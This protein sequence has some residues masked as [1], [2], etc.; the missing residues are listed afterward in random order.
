MLKVVVTAH[1]KFNKSIQQRGLMKTALRCFTRPVRGLMGALQVLSPTYRRIRREHAQWDVDHHVDTAPGNRP[2]WM[3]DI[4][5]ENW[6]HGRG[7]HPAPSESL[8]ERLQQL[9]TDFN[10]Y[11]FID[12]GS[13]KG[14]SLFTA[15][16]FPFKK[17]IGVEFNRSLHETA[18]KNVESY[19]SDQQQCF[20]IVPVL[21]DAARF[22]IPVGK[23]VFYFYDPFDETV[24]R[25][26]FEN[27][28][29]AISNSRE[30][31]F[32]VYYNPVF[33]EYFEEN[34]AFT[35]VAQGSEFENYWSRTRSGD[36]DANEF[37]SELKDSERYVVYESTL[38]KE[39][40]LQ[41]AGHQTN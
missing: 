7:Y 27:V 28:V 17:I 34:A 6:S 11:I 3:A 36:K 16:S 4:I 15:S 24:M 23:T 35:R 8:H 33:A 25:P 14:R 9:N 12:F 13:G 20:D 1:K 39:S 37:T 22:E 29:R 38:H 10:D 26:V 32:V 31:C 2:G 40:S 18:I 21:E 30:K 5:S 19:R 41:V